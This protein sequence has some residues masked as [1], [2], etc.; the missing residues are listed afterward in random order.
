MVADKQAARDPN[1]AFDEQLSNE[2][3]GAEI[4]PKQAR[5]PRR[6]RR[7]LSN[8]GSGDED[9]DYTPRTSKKKRT[10]SPKSSVPAHA[11]RSSMT[12]EGPSAGPQT[13]ETAHQNNAT[14]R[15]GPSPHNTTNLMERFKNARRVDP[16]SIPD[17]TQDSLASASQSQRTVDVVQQY[18]AMGEH[19]HTFPAQTQIARMSRNTSSAEVVASRD[20]T[21]RSPTPLH[22]QETMQEVGQEARSHA[23]RIP[24]QRA[25]LN[26]TL[27]MSH[28]TQP[29]ETPFQQAS[30]F[31]M[32]SSNVNVSNRA[33]PEAAQVTQQGV[34]RPPLTGPAS[35]EA[36]AIQSVLEPAEEHRRSAPTGTLAPE[37]QTE[38]T[39][40][41]HAA[42][43]GLD[44]GYKVIRSRRPLIVRNWRGGGLTGKS[45]DAFCDEIAA[46]IGRPVLRSI[47]FTLE[48]SRGG[49]TIEDQVERGN[50][51]DFE[52]MV[53]DFTK[54]IKKKRRDFGITEFDITIEPD[55]VLETAEEVG[56]NDDEDDDDGELYI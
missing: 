47:N 6:R 11:S 5:T 14:T 56:N 52:R 13:E 23:S 18:P 33:E 45:M 21:S 8:I 3:K 39:P 34:A 54:N 44:I 10:T 35:R 9:P 49:G 2:S 55:P 1:Y 28:V 4:S 22:V 38:P 32:M 53:K 50:L 20:A 51:E 12:Q 46:L 40:R 25:E 42:E 16:P 36:P 24:G 19:M 26:Q 7:I 41:P 30:R 27:P 17:S 37:Q 48:S 29:T 15:N 31:E 43:S